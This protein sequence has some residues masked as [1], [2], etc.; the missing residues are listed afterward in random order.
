MK[1]TWKN[2]A[3]IIAIV[4]GIVGY[5]VRFEVLA[6]EHIRTKKQVGD[7]RRVLCMLASEL[8]AKKTYEYCIGD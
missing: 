7:I 2:L 6:T 3:V 5:L 1:V 8:K 4:V